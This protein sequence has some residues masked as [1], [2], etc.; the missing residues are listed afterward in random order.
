M[1][2]ALLPGLARLLSIYLTNPDIL[3][4]ETL[5]RLLSTPAGPGFPALLIL[6]VLGNGFILTGML[7]GGFLAETINRRFGP[8]SVY[9]LL[10]SAL[11]LCG[12]IHS[13]FV[14]GNLFLPWRL[15]GMPR[16]VALQFSFA[17]LF[18]AAILFLL[19]KRSTPEPD[20]PA[21]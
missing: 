11:S 7:W 4:P 8:A 13:P 12:V 6:V 9:L 10:C 16:Q 5:A 1:G 14:D 21:P 18:A 20:A 3:P 19:A 15:D 2:L 17:Y